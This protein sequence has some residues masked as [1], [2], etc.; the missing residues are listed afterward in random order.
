MDVLADRLGVS[1]ARCWQ[2]FAGRVRVEIAAFSF[3]R[4]IILSRFVV[5]PQRERHPAV[6]MAI[7]NIVEGKKVCKLVHV[8]FGI[9]KYSY[10]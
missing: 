8:A 7:R 6:G 3:N 1:V 9:E 5:N 4:R 10:P 2:R